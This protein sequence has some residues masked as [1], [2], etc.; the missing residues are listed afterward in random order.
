M[1]TILRCLCKRITQ[2]LGFQLEDAVM[3]R[4]LAAVADNLKAGRAVEQVTVRT[5]LSWFGAQRRGWS[6][7]RQIREQLAEADFVTVPDSRPCA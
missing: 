5:F 4:E 6:I 2:L 7:V 1:L 3:I